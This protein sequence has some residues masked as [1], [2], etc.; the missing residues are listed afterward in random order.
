MLIM[1][2]PIDTPLKQMRSILKSIFIEFVP[3]QDIS[4]ITR[5]D[6]Q[7]DHFLHIKRMFQK[8]QRRCKSI[9][10]GVM[11]AV[12]KCKQYFTPILLPESILS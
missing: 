3:N 9:R 7:R 10:D 6:K 4:F 2:F 8:T 1:K 11:V 12:R 5:L